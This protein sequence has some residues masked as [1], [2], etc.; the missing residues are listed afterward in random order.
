M[1]EIK[2]LED[3]IRENARKALKDQIAAAAQPL[4]AFTHF[5]YSVE[6]SF[7]LH[8]GKPIQVWEALSAIQERIFAELASKREDEAIS[9]F[10][11]K[12]DELQTQLDE[13]KALQPVE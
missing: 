2:S 7:L 3:R 10:I 4:A 11:H 5:G 6:I 8:N 1:R 13:L 12:V 9:E